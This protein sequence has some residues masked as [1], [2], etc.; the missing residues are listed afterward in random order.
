LGECECHSAPMPTSTSFSFVSV[1]HETSLI[2][3]AR[4][5][6]LSVVYTVVV[7]WLL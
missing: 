5:D 1:T 3:C 6:V 7:L 2:F 4:S